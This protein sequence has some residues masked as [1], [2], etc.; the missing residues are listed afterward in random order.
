MPGTDTETRVAH[1][2]AFSVTGRGS[3]ETLSSQPIITAPEWSG[4]ALPAASMPMLCNPVFEPPYHALHGYDFGDV[5]ATA[6]IFQPDSLITN[7]QLSPLDLAD[8]PHSTHLTALD[9]NLIGG[10]DTESH[11]HL[12]GGNVI[13][14]GLPQP[15]TSDAV[16]SEYST[17]APSTPY[18]ETGLSRP[19]TGAPEPMFQWQGFLPSEVDYVGY[20]FGTV[21]PTPEQILEGI[22]ASEMD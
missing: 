21:G 13:T 10:Q 8:L 7:H 16:F 17:L 12:G 4:T 6:P 1:P 22:L 15:F 3:E 18:Q 9:Y 19:M 14:Q 2:P 5:N 11:S 20:F